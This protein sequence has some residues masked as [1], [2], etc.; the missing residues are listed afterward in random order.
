LTPINEEVNI[1]I[2]PMIIPGIELSGEIKDISLE[3]KSLKLFVSNFIMG[4][5][6]PEKII[7]IMILAKFVKGVRAD[8]SS[9]HKFSSNGVRKT[10]LMMRESSAGKNFLGVR[11]VRYA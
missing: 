2:R 7:K 1:I 4:E 9:F 5:N 8:L 10:L 6:N 11:V 3:R